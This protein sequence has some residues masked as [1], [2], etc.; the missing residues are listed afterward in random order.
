MEAIVLA[1]GLGTRLKSL[2]PN[3]P[4]PMAVVGGK[5]FLEHVLTYLINNGIR[6]IILSV[7]YKYEIIKKYFGD[8]FCGIPIVYSIENEP[9]GTGG[10]IFK[11]LS[12]VDGGSVYIINGDTFFNIDLKKLKL[13]NN[14]KV[15]IALKEMEKFDRYGCVE[16]DGKGYVTTFKEKQYSEKGYIN[17]GIYHICTNIFGTMYLPEKFSF[18]LLLQT[19]HYTHFN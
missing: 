6:K 2:V 8:S 10:A 16:I 18:E 19:L 15:A 7:G 12:K 3:A 4:K 14:S 13:K 9:L 1:G 17:G 11:A 5:P